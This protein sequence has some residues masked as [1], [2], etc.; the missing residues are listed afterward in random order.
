MGFERTFTDAREGPAPHGT[1]DVVV[2]AEHLSKRF[3]KAEALR[4][5]D[6]AIGRGEVFGLVGPDGAGKTTTMRLLAAI[7]RP[8]T[9]SAVVLGYDTVSQAEMIKAHVGYMAQQFTLYRDLSVRENLLFFADVFEV[10]GTERSDRIE[11]L[12]AFASLGQFA[13]RLAGQLSGGMQ[14]KLAL[15][16]TVIHEPDLLL[17]DEPTTGVDPVSRREFWEILTDLHLQGATIVI[18]TP[19]MDEAERCSRVGLLY[20]GELIECDTPERVRGMLAG[21]MLEVRTEDVAAARLIAAQV[22][23][24]V[25]VQVYGD[26]LHVMVDDAGKRARDVADAIRRSGVAVESVR[27]VSPR[28]EEAFI[29]LIRQH[30]GEGRNS[31]TAVGGPM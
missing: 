2:R 3:R 5:L 27:Q 13:D 30:E 6:L 17:L 28:M 1:S 23:G 31:S 10:V 12:L 15:A 11:R 14:K 25:E 16:C 7:M 29:S 24:V 4:D 19:Y 26:R 20:E 18:T 8:T 22:D 21:E 9:G